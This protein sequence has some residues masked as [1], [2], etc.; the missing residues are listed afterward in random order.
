[1]FIILSKKKKKKEQKKTYGQVCQTRVV[2]CCSDILLLSFFSFFMFIQT[3]KER[4]EKSL[5]A[6]F[7]RNDR[8]LFVCG[9]VFTET[10]SSLSSIKE[11]QGVFLQIDRCY[12][13][14]PPQAFVLQACTLPSPA[15]QVAYHFFNLSGPNTM[16][17]GYCQCCFLQSDEQ[18]KYKLVDY[19]RQ[20]APHRI[21]FC[22]SLSLKQKSDLQRG[23]LSEDRSFGGLKLCFRVIEKTSLCLCGAFSLLCELVHIEHSF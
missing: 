1:M 3:Q 4:E 6:I 12:R 15:N 20:K 2:S 23:H 7:K 17:P 9:N 5:K 13:S 19:E 10:Q 11:A 8:N 16:K 18:I 22:Y 21:Y 14:A